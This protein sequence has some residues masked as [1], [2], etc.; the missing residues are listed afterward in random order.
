VK[1]FQAR[2]F[3]NVEISF[4]FGQLI[5]NSEEQNTG[6]GGLNTKYLDKDG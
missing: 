1:I 5:S 2:S 6:E 4:K 3:V